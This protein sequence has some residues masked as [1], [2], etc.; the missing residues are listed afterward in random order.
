MLQIYR[1]SHHCAHSVPG[2]Q[3]LSA[4][5]RFGIVFLSLCSWTLCSWTLCSW[6]VCVLEPSVSSNP[7]FLSRLYSRPCALEPSAPEPYA[8][9]PSMIPNRVWSSKRPSRLSSSHLVPWI[10]PQYPTMN[11]IL[12]NSFYVLCTCPVYLSQNLNKNL[13][14]NNANV[15]RTELEPNQSIESEY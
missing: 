13:S 3:P 2:A 4:V 14:E 10:S 11:S 6:A 7:L 8:L 12:W 9:E 15:A 1:H 5:K